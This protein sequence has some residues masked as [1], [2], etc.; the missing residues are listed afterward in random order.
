MLWLQIWRSPRILLTLAFTFFFISIRTFYFNIPIADSTSGRS[1]RVS[2][3]LAILNRKVVPQLFEIKDRQPHY[4][5]YAYPGYEINTSRRRAVAKLIDNLKL[6]DRCQQ[7]P[8]T[9]VVDV[10]AS[11]GKFHRSINERFFYS[12]S[13]RTR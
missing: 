13:S 10:G 5:F 3:P 8:Q 12:L 4:S 9:L 11:V 7:N 2:I 1:A 6:H